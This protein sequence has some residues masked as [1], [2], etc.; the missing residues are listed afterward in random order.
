MKC[1][2]KHLYNETIPNA[3]YSLYFEDYI[4]YP[5]NCMVCGTKTTFGK[6][7]AVFCNDECTAYH[8]YICTRCKENMEN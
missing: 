5:V 2:Y 7:Y 8:K 4:N 1:K 6:T 3:I